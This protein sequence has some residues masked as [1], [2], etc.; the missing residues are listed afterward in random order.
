MEFAIDLADK[1]EPIAQ[2]QM[3]LR[4]KL[5][6]DNVTAIAFK[7][8]VVLEKMA[9]VAWELAKVLMAVAVLMGAGIY[10][11]LALVYHLMDDRT[12]MVAQ[13]S[14]QADEIEEDVQ[15][16]DFLVMTVAQLRNMA[17]ADGIRWRDVRGAGKHL[18]RD[19]LAEALW[20]KQRE[21]M[22]A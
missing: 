12:A 22:A 20:Q 9:I 16:G 14:T 21:V 2:L 1:F 8:A 11:L 15:E 18:R 5:T 4:S 10:F 13:E 7:T 19:E 6:Y 17:D 3:A